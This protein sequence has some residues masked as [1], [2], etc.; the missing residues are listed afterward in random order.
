MSILNHKISVGIDGK[1]LFSF[2][3]LK[4]HQSINNHHSFEL[5][6]DLEAGG[7]QICPQ[8]QGQCQMDWKVIR[9]VCR[10]E[11]GNYLHGGHYGCEPAQEEQ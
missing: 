5:L 8:P 10:R 9:R 1:K 2:K 4:L 6:L 11:F 3:S 7:E